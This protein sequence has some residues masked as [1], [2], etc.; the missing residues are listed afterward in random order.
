[1]YGSLDELTNYY[2]SGLRDFIDVHA[3]LI[4][5]TVTPR[6]HA[7]WY[8]EELRD[9]KQL[10]RKLERK[11]R[12]SQQQSDRDAY[13][14]QCAEVAKQL[15]RCKTQYYSNRV[16]E[17][18][19]DQ[20]SLFK[21]TD[22][23]LVNQHQSKLPASDDDVLLA[24]NFNNFFHDKIEIIRAI[25]SCEELE[26][27]ED[28]LTD[29][30]LINLRPAT[31]DEINVIILSCSN[32]SCLLDPVPTWLLKECIGDLLPLITAIVNTSISTEKFPKTLKNAIV[33]PHLKNQKLD[34]EE[35]KHYRPVSNINFLSKIIEKC[36]V[37][38]LEE[39][40]HANNL[41]DPLQ[42]AY[43]AQHAT[44][45]AILKINNDILGGLDKGKCTVLASLDLSAAFDTVDY[46]IFLKKLQNLYG[47]EQTALQ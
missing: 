6:P 9:S 3:P 27:Q 11:W 41:Y 30:K 1:M 44:E 29:M 34:P 39:Y 26:T 7:A 42:S 12:R 8:D 36:V 15:N 13:R 14:K 5:R 45:T 47:V 17:C 35:L 25:L 46:A 37:K 20:K 22:T 32:S 10:Q 16:E 4:S 31:S 43:R 21:I 38:R 18:H 24:N 19:N 33:R 2:M 28:M 40:M 23:L